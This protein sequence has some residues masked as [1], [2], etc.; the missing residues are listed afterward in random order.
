MFDELWDE[1]VSWKMPIV[2]DKEEL[3]F[4]VDQCSGAK[5]Y[6]EIGTSFGGS[7]WPIANMLDN[8]A[9]I[10]SVDMPKVWNNSSKWD[11]DKRTFERVDWIAE[12]LREQGKT[13]HIIRGNSLDENIVRTVTELGPYE[14]CFIDGDHSYNAIKQDYENYG[15][16]AK[17]IIFHDT[18]SKPGVKQFWGELI[19]EKI[20]F[21]NVCGVGIVDKNNAY[22]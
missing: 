13:V 17:R 21:G 1:V 22:I 12:Q 9:V 16:L 14:I 7:L 6:L 10:V 15:K 20:E 11:R 4:I 18:L 5:S 2:Q 19:G 8:N 3:R